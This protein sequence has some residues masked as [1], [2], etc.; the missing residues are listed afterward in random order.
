QAEWKVY[1]D[2]QSKTKYDLSRG[3]WV[4]DYKDPNTFLDLFT[5]HNGNNRTGWSNARYDALLSKANQERDPGVREKLLQEAETLL[6]RDEVPLLPIYIYRGQLFFDDNKWEG[7]H[8]N[9]I[10]EH[11]LSAI[12]RKGEPQAKR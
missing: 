7:I 11:P 12:R 6:V 1:L 2:L 9:L 5:S 3:S 10:D 4:G 8:G